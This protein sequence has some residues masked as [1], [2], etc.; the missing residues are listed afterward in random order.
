MS[1]T[2]EISDAIKA[3]R[4]HR[5]DDCGHGFPKSKL[6]WHHRDPESKLFN[7]AASGPPRGASLALPSVQRLIVEIEKCDL[8]CGPCHVARHVAM[9]RAS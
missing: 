4:S 2:T 5:C 3:L 8:L 9:R 1:S 6:H 7:V